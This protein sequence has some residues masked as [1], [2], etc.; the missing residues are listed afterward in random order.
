MELNLLQLLEN[1]FNF[2]ANLLYA[3]QVWGTKLINESSWS[4]MFG[5]VENGSSTFAL[6]VISQ[7]FARAQ[8]FAF[9]EI[10]FFNEIT[11]VS[12]PPNEKG[13]RLSLILAPFSV[14]IWALIVLSTVLIIALLTFTG[15]NTLD[16]V[17][18]FLKITLKQSLTFTSST[19][20]QVGVQFL[21]GLWIV[22]TLILSTFYTSIYFSILTV[23]Q[24][25]K[26][27]D[28]IE[29]LIEVA[30]S[31]SFQVILTKNSL[32]HQQI[33]TSNK[34]DCLFYAI[35]QHI[36]RTKSRIETIMQNVHL[37]E[38]VAVYITTPM[39]STRFLTAKNVVMHIAQDRIAADY[40][41]ILL[42]KECFLKKWFD[43]M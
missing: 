28:S 6:C 30:N 35:G 38:R 13:T 26:P 1:R 14:L 20:S 10:L 3:H 16:L 42:R 23:P 11:F 7:S 37:F 33:M 32:L 17:V 29:D 12:P 31:D 8:S 2:R 27:I 25:T 36:N 21:V 19:K 4:G 22:S 15:S 24:T 41:S 34:D 43:P 40:L 39:I 18:V 9:T 5:M